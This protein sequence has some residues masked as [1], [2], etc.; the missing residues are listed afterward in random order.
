MTH[1][2]PTRR[3]SH[4]AR[5]DDSERSSLPRGD[6]SRR[7]EH[8]SAGLRYAHTVS[9]SR[10]FAALRSVELSKSGVSSSCRVAYLLASPAQQKSRDASVS[11]LQPL[12]PVSVLP[13]SAST[14]SSHGLSK[15]PRKWLQSLTQASAMQR[16]GSMV[17]SIRHHVCLRH[18]SSK[19][20]NGAET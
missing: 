5:R 20:Q 8:S 17:S 18:S 10:P 16:G 4:A 7:L 19:S 15:L 9:E 3:A 13:I 11:H 1:P 12:T 2:I 14:R 6:R